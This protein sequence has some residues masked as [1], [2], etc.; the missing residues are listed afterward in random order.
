MRSLGT[1]ILPDGLGP[2]QAN[3]VGLLD[4]DHSGAAAAGDPQQVTADL[5]QPL[6]LDG[7]AGGLVATLGGPEQSFPVRVREVAKV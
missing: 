7:F 5:G 1:R 2:V 4:F 3:G 6:R